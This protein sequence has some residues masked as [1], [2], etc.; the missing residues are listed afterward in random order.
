MIIHE[1]DEADLAAPKAVGKRGRC[2]IC[3]DL[4]VFTTLRSRQKTA[5]QGE[6]LVRRFCRVL[7]RGLSLKRCTMG[8]LD[9]ASLAC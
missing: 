8:K 1:G 3:W 4:H 5:S 9:L 7:D 6:R 2:G